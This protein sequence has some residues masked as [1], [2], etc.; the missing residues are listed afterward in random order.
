MGSPFFVANA[1]ATCNR[2]SKGPAIPCYNKRKAI[3]KIQKGA[4]NEIPEGFGTN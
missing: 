3:Q 2:N 1:N 4:K